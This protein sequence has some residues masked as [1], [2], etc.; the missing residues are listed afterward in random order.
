MV[1]VTWL[2]VDFRSLYW[3]EMANQ[4][5]GGLHKAN[6]N[7]SNI[8]LLYNRQHFNNLSRE[9]LYDENDCPDNPPVRRGYT[10]DF[11]QRE[12]FKVYWSHSTYNHIVVSGIDVRHCK[13]FVN[14]TQPKARMYNL[15]SVTPD[16]QNG[17]VIYHNLIYYFRFASALHNCR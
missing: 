4:I 11:S 14:S 3:V 13:I 8:R 17:E 5:T 1:S 12:H 16:R 15:F 7:G 6:Y 2:F 10:L 9:D